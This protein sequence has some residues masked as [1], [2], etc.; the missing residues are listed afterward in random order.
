MQI[1]GYV[2]SVTT[3][4]INN[5][6]ATPFELLAK[7]FLTMMNW[8]G[9]SLLKIVKL[10]DWG[11]TV[12]KKILQF[13]GKLLLRQSDF[14][15]Q[16]IEKANRLGNFISQELIALSKRLVA[17]GKNLQQNGKEK[18]L[19]KQTE[20]QRYFCKGKNKRLLKRQKPIQRCRKTGKYEYIL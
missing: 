6:V 3:T 1:V 20:T 9:E 10:E 18:R 16:L 12:I 15:C 2:L 8:F 11:N 5:F 19:K 7:A 17:K 13:F 14:G 4:L